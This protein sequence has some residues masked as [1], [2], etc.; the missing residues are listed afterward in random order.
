MPL[1]FPEFRPQ[2]YSVIPVKI[3]V[4]PQQDSRLRMATWLGLRA[5]PAPCPHGGSD[6]VLHTC[7]LGGVCGRQMWT[8]QRARN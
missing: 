2:A 3:G 4:I 6:S 8:V 1:G 5:R 7:P